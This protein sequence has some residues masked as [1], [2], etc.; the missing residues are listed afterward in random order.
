MESKKKWIQMNLLTKQKETHRLRKQ[1]Q[2]SQGEEI[3]KDFGKVMY[4]LLHLK[5]ITNKNLLYSTWN[6]AQ[7]YM[8]AM[9]GEFW[10]RTDACICMAESLHCSPETIITL[11]MAVPQ[12]TMFLE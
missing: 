2:G 5:W 10:G 3:V 12:L 8:P 9:M 4:T 1:T 7:C 6:S 11:L